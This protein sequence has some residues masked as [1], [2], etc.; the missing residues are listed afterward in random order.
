M[1]TVMGRP[2][3]EMLALALLV[4]SLIEVAVM[5]TVPPAGTDDGAV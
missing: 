4:P 1:E 3:M 2:V 5:V